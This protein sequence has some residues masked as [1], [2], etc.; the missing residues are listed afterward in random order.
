MITTLNSRLIAALRQARHLVV[1]TGAGVSAESGIPT[2]R[3]RLTGVWAH[4]DPA[5]VATPQAFRRDPQRVWDWHVYLAAAMRVAQPNAAHPAIAA[6]AGKV[7]DCA[8]DAACTDALPPPSFWSAQPAAASADGTA[9]VAVRAA[10]L[11]AISGKK[12]PSP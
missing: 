12:P 4:T 9:Q 6:L 10:V 5:E 8:R 2:F 3:D 1:F 7:V 11:L